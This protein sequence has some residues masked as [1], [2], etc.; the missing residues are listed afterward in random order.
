MTNTR[1]FRIEWNIQGQRRVLACEDNDPTYIARTV[2]K[3]ADK[4]KLGEMK[5]ANIE[6]IRWDE[7]QALLSQ[8]RLHA[9]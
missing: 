7:Y 3:V 8:A 4:H 1:Y 9:Q 5:D 6:Q 2:R